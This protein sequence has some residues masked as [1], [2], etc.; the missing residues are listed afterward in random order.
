MKKALLFLLALCFGLSVL[1]ACNNGSEADTLEGTGEDTTMVT[2]AMT[3]AETF[4]IIEQDSTEVADT[5]TE[6]V[7]NKITLET[8]K[9]YESGEWPG[10]SSLHFGNN[11]FEISVGEV[12]DDFDVTYTF[13]PDYVYGPR[14][15]HVEV[16]VDD[17]EVV[18]VLSVD[19]YATFGS[20]NGAVVVKGL[21]AGT[22]TITLKYIFTETGGFQTDTATVT[23]T[24][25]T[26][27]ETSEDTL[28]EGVDVS[29][30]WKVNFASQVGSGLSYQLQVGETLDDFAINFACAD[31]RCNRVHSTNC[32]YY[33][34]SWDYEDYDFEVVSS[35]PEVVEIV[36]VDKYAMMNSNLYGGLV[37]KGLQQG[38]AEIQI[39]MTHI[40]TGKEFIAKNKAYV[41]VL[42]PSQSETQKIFPSAC[43]FYFYGTDIAVGLDEEYLIQEFSFSISDMA[44]MNEEDWKFELTV[45]DP[46]VLQATMV[47]WEQL[48]DEQ[49]LG[50]VVVKGLSQGHTRVTLTVTYLPTG[51]IHSSSTTVTVTT[52]TE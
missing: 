3:G 27:E 28:P 16:I 24:E 47:D 38:S 6:A 34:I 29:E 11:L 37:V 45:D 31:K 13:N 43:R 32:Q 21:K 12:F 8:Q 18:E 25:S 15:Y 17:P 2:E 44:Y 30:V 1:V 14:Y 4:V 40:P 49:S 20:Q 42:T 50:G 52:P 10:M 23:V 7:T 51:G 26:Q 46:S 19:R 36:S 9:E 39:T 35:D 33:G 22:T 41:T 48:V 5:E